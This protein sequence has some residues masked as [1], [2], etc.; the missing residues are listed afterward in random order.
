MN[1]ILDIANKLLCVVNGV[2]AFLCVVS[3]LICWAE[4]DIYALM[5][6]L[7]FPVAFL[8]G[9]VVY[10]VY[11]FSKTK[12]TLSLTIGLSGLIFSIF[13]I[14]GASGLILDFLEN[15]TLYI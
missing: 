15:G 3:G 10:L 6:L 1:K 9:A 2:A 13:S 4:G 8:L 11:R 12:Q 14:I 7:W 5:V